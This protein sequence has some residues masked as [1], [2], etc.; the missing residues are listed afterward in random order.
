MT[1]VG[2]APVAQ[3]VWQASEVRNEDA[4]RAWDEAAEEFSGFMVEGGDFYHRHII[5]PS[6]LDLLGEIEG[7]A[8]LD[9][10]CGNGHLSRQL[11]TISGRNVRVLGIDAS[12]AM[13]R[14]ARERSRDFVDCLTFEQAD[15]GDL[16][17]VPADSFDV[18]LCNMALMD[19]QDYG[20]AI[21][22]V[23]R[24]LE[25]GGAFL[26][27]ILHPC[28]FTPLSGWLLNESQEVVGWRVD[29]Y[30]SRLVGRQAVKSRMVSQTYYFHRT[31]EDYSS[32]LRDNGFVITD[33]RE[34]VP[35][36]ECIEMRPARRHQ[37]R[38]GGF[39]V[40]RSVLL[41]QVP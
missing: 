15:A 6:L 36:D 19:I 37:L 28:F 32:A 22:E 17:D 35:P 30:H 18:A 13:I 9:V 5:I 2:G 11:A 14:I 10:G 3:Q 40:V 31:L 7:R 4:I 39:L 34:P 33:I 27:S 25:P 23:A 24:T 1:A 21:S 41:G 12:A 8:V 20:Q 16:A 26:F 38:R 29:G